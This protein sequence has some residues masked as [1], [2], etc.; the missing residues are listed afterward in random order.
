MQLKTSTKISL[1]FTFFATIILL[2]FSLVIFV[3]FF[4]TRYSKQKAR[5]SMNME[6]EP[7]FLLEFVHTGPLG[8]TR[9]E[10]EI[11]PSSRR[12]IGPDTAKLPRA[13]FSKDTTAF[14]EAP[15]S[16]M[17]TDNG[18]YTLRFFFFLSKGKISIFYKDQQYFLY[19]IIDDKVKFLDITG[20][21]Y[22]Q[23]ELVQLLF[24]WDV[25]FIVVVYLISL[26]FVRSSLKNLKKLTA[27][28]QHLDLDHLCVPLTIK[29]HQHDE[30]KV[31]S[32]A[33]NASLEKIHTQILALKD[34]IANASHELKTPLMMISSEIDIALK[35]KDYEERL[36]NIKGHVKRLSELLDTLSLITR[37][38]STNTFERKEVNVGDT[39]QK[40]LSEMEKKYPKKQIMVNIEKNLTLQ[41]HPSLLEIIL[42]NLIENACKYAGEKAKI[43][44]TGTAT[45]LSVSDTGVGIAPEFQGQIFERFWQ[46]EK[47]EQEGH[48]F[49]L[50]LYLVKKIVELHGWKIRV[51]SEVG[52]G[53]KFVIEF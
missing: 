15:L 27:F 48:S 19:E 22:A 26:Y 44:V 43:T 21:I 4:A 39:V 3:L 53:A 45:S 28:A 41:A 37:L 1:K 5:F 31:I 12:E 34:F 51:E 8:T 20:F 30:I 35:K 32:D 23:T 18:Y 40:V 17:T 2:F 11:D 25:F 52:K 38:E 46:M 47:T 24:L 9:Q 29:G 14:Q 13:L 36:G 7:P 6:Y 50:G 10:R 16:E 33:F 49:G 42:K